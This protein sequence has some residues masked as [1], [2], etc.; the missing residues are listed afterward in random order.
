MTVEIIDPEL[1]FFREGLKTRDI[2]KIDKIIL[3]HS[4]SPMERTTIHS[5]HRWHLQRGW[6][7]CG[8]HYVIHED[9]SIFQ[10]RPLN[11]IGAHARGYNEHSIGICTVGNFEE[12]LPTLCQQEALG[13]LLLYFINDKFRSK[14]LTIMRHKDVAATLCPG[15]NFTYFIPVIEHS[16]VK[17]HQELRNKIRNVIN[18][19]QEL[20]QIVKEER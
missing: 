4:G 20:K 10:G 14:H 7:G 11:V 8:Y 9:G 13:K 1:K 3:H 18:T 5:I 15:R 16:R 19:I 6:L 2:F 17:E 12:E